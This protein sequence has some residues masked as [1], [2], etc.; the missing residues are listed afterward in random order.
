[1]KAPSPVNQGPEPSAPAGKKKPGSLT[2]AQREEVTRRVLAGERAVRLAAE[3]GVTKAYVSLLKHQAL[4]PERFRKKKEDKLSRKLTEQELEVFKNALN[5][6]TPQTH[7]LN[8]PTGRWTEKYAK[9]LAF[10]LFGKAISVRVL[11]ECL[12]LNR[13]V[14]KP[15][16]YERPKPPGPRD[17][18]LL[19]LEAASDPEFVAWYLSPIAAQIAQRSYEAALRDYDERFGPDGELKVK[20]RGRGRPSAKE[21]TAAGAAGK[22][23][24]VMDDDIPLTEAQIREEMRAMDQLSGEWPD[25]A[26]WPLASDPIGYDPPLPPAPGQRIGKHAKSKG[27]NHTPPKRKKKRR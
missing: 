8:A 4:E 16:V 18:R 10:K 25:V 24:A 19:S 17:I 27:T 1:M 21:K 15:W 12:N 14:Q 6:E 22:E 7:G 20:K 5:H 9:E 26:N 23:S 2:A 13:P 3:Y 11:K